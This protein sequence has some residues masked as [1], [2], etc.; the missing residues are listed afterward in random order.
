MRF[1]VDECM[2]HPKSLPGLWIFRIPGILGTESI[3]LLLVEFLEK[4]DSK[5]LYGKLIVFSPGRIRIRPI[6]R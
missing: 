5:D 6:Q 4:T 2:P 3:G 1:L